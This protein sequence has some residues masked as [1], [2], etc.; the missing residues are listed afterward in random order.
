MKKT[1]QPIA[2]WK[3]C[4]GIALTILGIIYFERIIS[5]DWRVM[6]NL[7]VSPVIGAVMAYVL[8][9]ILVK[10]ERLY[11]PN[12][13]NKWIN[14]T[15]RPVCIL[16]SIGII[17]II[18]VLLLNVVIPELISAFEVIGKSIPIYAEKVR[19]WALDHS[20]Q[21]PAVE[22]WLESMKIDWPQFLKNAAAYVTSGL[23]GILN[24]TV[25]FVGVLGKGVV[26]F[27]LGVIFCCIYSFQQGMA[28][29]TV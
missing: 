11:W 10:A 1:G 12:S 7:D 2:L 28:C 5:G 27:V 24:S 16:I 23:G 22:Q 6:G 9:I 15:R 25:V 13:R 4:V 26:N 18:I 19:L 14:K 21:L 17:V 29:Q 3:I 8:N 20:D